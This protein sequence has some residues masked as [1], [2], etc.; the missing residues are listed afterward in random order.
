MKSYLIFILGSVQAFAKS[1]AIS[2]GEVLIPNLQLNEAEVDVQVVA[3]FE[4][5]SFGVGQM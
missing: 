3:Y 5:V 4:L 2:V 1:W